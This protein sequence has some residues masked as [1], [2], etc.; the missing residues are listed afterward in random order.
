MGA[1]MKDRTVGIVDSRGSTLPVTA[2]CS[3]SGSNELW[4]G[5]SCEGDQR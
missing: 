3:G 1:G 4:V 5:G 2:E